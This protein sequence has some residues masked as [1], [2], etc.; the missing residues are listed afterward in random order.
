[1]VKA[2]A[3]RKRVLLNPVSL[4]NFSDSQLKEAQHR[5]SIHTLDSSGVN[6]PPETES[7]LGQTKE[8]NFEMLP[9]AIR[10]QVGYKT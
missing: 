2:E 6:F 10:K 3:S 1:M 5:F 4:S 7:I 9:Y 8:T